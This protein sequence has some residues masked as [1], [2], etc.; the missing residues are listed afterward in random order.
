MKAGAHTVGF[1]LSALLSAEDF[2]SVMALQ[3]WIHHFYII[4]RNCVQIDVLTPT[5]L[6][7][8][9]HAKLIGNMCYRNLVKNLGLLQ[10]YEALMSDNTTASLASFDM[11]LEKMGY[12]EGT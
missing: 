4:Y 5:W 7:G 12:I 8:S 6:V 9:C 10:T 3:N 2:S 1:L 11:S